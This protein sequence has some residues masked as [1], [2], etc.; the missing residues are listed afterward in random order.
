MTPYEYCID[1]GYTD[2]VIFDRFETA[3]MGVSTDNRAVYSYQKMITYLMKE[4]GMDY[5][6]AVEFLDFNTIPPQCEGWPVIFNE[7]F[8]CDVA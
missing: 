5:G 2:I 6:E 8:D 7:V 4:D 1:M 3:F